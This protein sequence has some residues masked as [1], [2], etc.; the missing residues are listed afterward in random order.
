MNPDVNILFDRI[1]GDLYN[2]CSDEENGYCRRAMYFG[3]A[4]MM[5]YYTQTFP[6]FRQTTSAVA[7]IALPGN[8]RR[9]V[10]LC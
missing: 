8:S 3:Y 10:M 2:Y 7:R 1:I 6:K 5:K 4:L 9:F